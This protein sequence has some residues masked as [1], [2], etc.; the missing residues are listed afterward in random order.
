[1]P[2]KTR[3]ASATRL[4]RSRFNEAAARC[5]GKPRLAQDEILAVV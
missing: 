3:V 5:R 4:R 1:M 2:R